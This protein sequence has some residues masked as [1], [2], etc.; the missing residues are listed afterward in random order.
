MRVLAW[1]SH[2][3]ALIQIFKTGQDIH[4]AVAAKVFNVAEADI[5]REMRRKA[6]V[7]NFGILYGMGVSSLKKNLGGTM[8]EA[9]KFYDNFFAQ[10][11]KV[12]KYFEKIKNETRK[13]GY[14]ETAYGRRR[15]FPMI[16]S[17]LP[18]VRAEAE[19]M[20]VNAVLQGTAT[21]DLIKMAMLKVDTALKDHGFHDSARLILQVHDELLYEIKDDKNFSETARLIKGTM[22]NVD[23]LPI[24]LLVNCHTGNS[25]GEMMA[26]S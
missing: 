4:T 16:N 15:Y 12:K 11:P 2:D 19:R 7:I 6:K 17:V 8:D 22:E 10:F 13:N 20:A 21:A 24:T 9:Q 18:Y 26:F 14:T 25:W 23:K 3:E 5:T 1:L